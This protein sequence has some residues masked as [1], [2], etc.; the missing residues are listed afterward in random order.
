LRVA[1]DER[2]LRRGERDGAPVDPLGKL[3]V[4]RVVLTEGTPRPELVELASG[5]A[6]RDVFEGPP[7]VVD[8][9]EVEER[10]QKMAVV[11]V[12]VPALRRTTF[13]C[14]GRWRVPDVDILE[15]RPHLG[16]RVG[17]VEQARVDPE[18]QPPVAEAKLRSPRVLADD[19]LLPG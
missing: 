2:P 6:T 9:D 8:V 12:A 18:P 5:S 14:I 7:T 10:L 19:E 17:D 1:E 3:V 13:F 4:G 11:E 15:L 16:I